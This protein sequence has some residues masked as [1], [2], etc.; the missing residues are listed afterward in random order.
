MMMR[1]KFNLRMVVKINYDVDGHE[2]EDYDEG[3]P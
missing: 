1:V 2:H 3:Q